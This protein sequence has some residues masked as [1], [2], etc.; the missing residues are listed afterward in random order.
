[1]LELWRHQLHAWGE[2][3]VIVGGGAA[4]L[5]GL[6]FVVISIGPHTVSARTEKQ[7][8]AFVTPSVVYFATVLVAAAFMTMPT[9]T[10]GV[11]SALLALGG[12]VG[13]IYIAWIG[14]HRQ[15]R[16]STL[17]RD[18]WLWY[19]GLPVLGYVVLIAAAFTLW[20]GHELA[21]ETVAGA[22][23]LFLVIG[24]R[25]AWDLV[26]WMAQQPRRPDAKEPVI[27]ERQPGG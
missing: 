22:M 1:M 25:N 3:Y 24:I 8:R 4:A 18:D 11:L 6:M 13:L 14:V 5:T 2:F 26:I 23:I 27:D 21:L 17:E 15:W 10:R 9:L 20:L 7:R 16:E 19:V 12:V